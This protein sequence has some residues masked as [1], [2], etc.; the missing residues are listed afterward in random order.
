MEKQIADL[1]ARLQQKEG[2]FIKIK[3]NM[4]DL[5]E[6]S[7]AKD[8]ESQVKDLNLSIESARR[9][10]KGTPSSDEYEKKFNE[11]SREFQSLKDQLREAQQEI[12]RKDEGLKARGTGPLNNSTVEE[13]LTQAVDKISQ[14]GLVINRLVRKL[15]DCG[16]N[17]DLTKD[18]AK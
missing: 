5:Q 2:E 15:Q 14:Q 4:Y 9:G 6:S 17:V 18:L 10:V 7:S 1:N 13:K 12:M 16:Q 8:K 3:K 11:Q